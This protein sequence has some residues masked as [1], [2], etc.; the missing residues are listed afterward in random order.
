LK[1][2]TKIYDDYDLGD[3]VFTCPVIDSLDNCD[4][5]SIL[6]RNYTSQKELNKLKKMIST[7][8][9]QKYGQSIYYPHELRQE[10]N[11]IQIPA[12][13]L[14]NDYITTMALYADVQIRSIYNLG[15]AKNNPEIYSKVKE[16][17]PK[18]DY[19]IGVR[20]LEQLKQNME[21]FR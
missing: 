9:I 20:N 7:R 1:I 19:V 8:R 16:N 14:F 15:D 10:A 5:Y 11:I 3:G 13:A 2:Q 6:Y 4:I 18:I 17:F 12:N 21:L